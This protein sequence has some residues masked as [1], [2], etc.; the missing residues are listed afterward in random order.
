[1]RTKRRII[2]INC[3]AVVRRKHAPALCDK[4][5]EDYADEVQGEAESLELVHAANATHLDQ[6]LKGHSAAAVRRQ[7]TLARHRFGF[8]DARDNATAFALRVDAIEGSFCDPLGH[9]SY[10]VA[11]AWH[12]A[13]LQATRLPP[14]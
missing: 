3:A 5:L 2:E 1:M 4:S 14:P 12:R 10:P 11:Y 6:W 7:L 13:H 9:V 8:A